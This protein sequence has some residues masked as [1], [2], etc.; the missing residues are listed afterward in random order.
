M[1]VQQKTLALMGVQVWQERGVVAETMI[2]PLDVKCL[3][4]LA[5]REQDFSESHHTQIMKILE[6]LNLHTEYALVFADGAHHQT[7]AEFALG[8]GVPYRVKGQKFACQTLS[9][10]EMLKNPSCKRQVLNDLKPL[11]DS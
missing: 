2:T 11:K 5:E 7:E 1:S 10:S 3:A 9:V 4:F 6:F 8:F